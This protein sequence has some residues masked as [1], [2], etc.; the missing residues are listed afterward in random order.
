MFPCLQ[1][2]EEQGI[3]IVTICALNIAQFFLD[4]TM[5]V[6]LFSGK[7]FVGLFVTDS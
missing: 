7:I 2:I 5:S 1:S 4:A 3:S 6:R